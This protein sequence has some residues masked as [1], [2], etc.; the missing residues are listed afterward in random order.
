MYKISRSWV[1]IVVKEKQRFLVAKDDKEIAEES[2]NDFEFWESWPEWFSQ[3]VVEK[4][5]IQDK[6]ILW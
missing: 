4:V 2:R 5:H 6:M 1:A 3:F